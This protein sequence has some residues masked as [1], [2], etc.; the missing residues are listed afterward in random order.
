MGQ[1]YY[2]SLIES[3]M[4][5]FDLSQNKS[6]I[7]DDIEL[8]LRIIF[9]LLNSNFS[10]RAYCTRSLAREWTRC[11]RVW[12]VTV[13][14]LATSSSRSRYHVICSRPILRTESVMICHRSTS[15]ADEITLCLVG[16]NDNLRH[17]F[18]TYI[19]SLRYCLNI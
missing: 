13:H 17:L 12:W 9:M 4:H 5:A 6:T 16:R 14:K 7:F 3:C 19:L 8:P 10:T 15:S 18:Y 1:S 11:W 2:W